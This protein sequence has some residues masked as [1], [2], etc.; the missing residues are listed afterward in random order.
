MEEEIIRG[1]IVLWDLKKIKQ[2]RQ[3]HS[4]VKSFMA[5]DVVT[6]STETTP[7]EAAR[8]MI[9]K[10]VGYLPVVQKGKV[11]GMVTR[12]DILTYYYDLLPD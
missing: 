9:Q 4:P 1:I 2:E 12:T 10:N 5:K 6:I 8:L 7:N 11:I 3:W